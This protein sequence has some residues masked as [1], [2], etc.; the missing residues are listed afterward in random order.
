MRD[1]GAVGAITLLRRITID[2]NRE[3]QVELVL[4]L[5]KILNDDTPQRFEGKNQ[6]EIKTARVYPGWRDDS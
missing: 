6:G 3:L 5:L 2:R 4:N 1:G